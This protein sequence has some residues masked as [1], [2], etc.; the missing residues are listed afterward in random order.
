MANDALDQAAAEMENASRKGAREDFV[1]ISSPSDGDDLRLS[2]RFGA[3]SK[4]E[5]NE[6]EQRNT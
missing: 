4:Q 5:R 6:T 1:H 3:G 2:N